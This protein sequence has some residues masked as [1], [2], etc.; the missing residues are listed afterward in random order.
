MKIEG[1]LK[2]A[3]PIIIAFSI[4]VVLVLFNAVTGICARYAYASFPGPSDPPPPPS[5]FCRGH[6]QFGNIAAIYIAFLVLFG[7][8]GTIWEGVARIFNLTRA[9]NVRL[10]WFFLVPLAI[11]LVVYIISLLN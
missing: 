7:F 5:L 10:R 9:S 2:V 8:I 1:W 3:S 4:L 6:I 11:T